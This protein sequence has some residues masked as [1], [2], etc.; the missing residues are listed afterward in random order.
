MSSDQQQ[1][2]KKKKRSGSE[3]RRRTVMNTFRSSPEDRAEMRA[4]AAAAGLRFGSFMVLLGCAKPTTRATPTV[5]LDRT[6][7]NKFLG[8][9]GKYEGNLYQVVRRMNFG[10]FPEVRELAELADDAR[11]F[12]DAARAVLKGA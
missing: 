6:A 7:I 9:V 8:R 3:K 1:L 5:S 11:A 12:L 2:P 10:N 4:A